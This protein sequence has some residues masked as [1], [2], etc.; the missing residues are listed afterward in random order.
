MK[1]ITTLL[2]DADE[3]L[4]SGRVYNKEMMAKEFERYLN[5]SAFV[6]DRKKDE[7]IPDIRDIIGRVDNITWD[8]NKAFATITLHDTPKGKI[9]QECMETMGEEC[10]RFLPTGHGRAIGNEV[11]DYELISIDLSITLAT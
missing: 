9:T 10:F 3:K 2:Y 5:T 1:T 11:I 7:P 4:P 8:R 6:Y